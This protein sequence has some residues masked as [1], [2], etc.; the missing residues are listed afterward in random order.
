MKVSTPRGRGEL[1]E[2]GEQD[3]AD[4]A[5]LPGVVDLEGDLGAAGRVRHEAGMRD[6]APRGTGERQ[7][8]D[9]VG[10]QAL[11]CTAQA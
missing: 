3:R 9:A 11:G 2:V 6:R 10:R 8:A 4:S 7:Q 1:G 5:P